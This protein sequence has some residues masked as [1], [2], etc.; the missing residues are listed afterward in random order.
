MGGFGR[1]LGR[2]WR[3]LVDAPGRSWTLL[4]VSLDAGGRSWPLLEASLDAEG[5]SW[6]FLDASWDVFW[7]SCR[8]FDPL[9]KVSA[10]LGK[11]SWSF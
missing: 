1:V 4:E 9:G 10:A 2:F 11:H 5:R 7:W 8:S 3:G 6:K